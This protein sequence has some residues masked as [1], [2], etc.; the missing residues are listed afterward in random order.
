MIPKKIIENTIK[1]AN[2]INRKL[3]IVTCIKQ[4]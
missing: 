4:Q 2:Y 1:Y 3:N